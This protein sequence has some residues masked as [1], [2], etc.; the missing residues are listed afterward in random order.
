MSLS[1]TALSAI[2]QVSI[3][4]AGLLLAIYAL[5][6]PVSRKIFI[7]RAMYLQRKTAEFEKKRQTLTPQAS[8]D[9]FKALQ[10]LSGD[11][12]E[13]KQFP[14]ILS[15][16]VIFSFA[17]YTLTL[18][19]SWVALVNPLYNNETSLIMINIFFIVS[20]GFFLSLVRQQREPFLLQ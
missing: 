8:A 15:A 11:I 10:R 5:I 17:A 12:K 1:E 20:N 16:G 2:M 14:K 6:I 9:E 13:T 19:F 7:S 18:F 4:G 3:T